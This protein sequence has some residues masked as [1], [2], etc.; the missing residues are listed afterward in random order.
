MGGE[1]ATLFGT[2]SYIEM[3]EGTPELQPVTGPDKDAAWANAGASTPQA[4]TAGSATRQATVLSKCGRGL[5]RRRDILFASHSRDRWKCALGA[6][7]CRARPGSLPGALRTRSY[8]P[9]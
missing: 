1:A 6:R 4:M 7:S 5:A 8:Q 2:Y 9:A 3:Y